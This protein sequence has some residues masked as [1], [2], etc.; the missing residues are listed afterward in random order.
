[1]TGGCSDDGGAC[2]AVCVDVLCSSFF[3]FLFIEAFLGNEFLF[4]FVYEW[5]RANLNMDKIWM[6][7]WIRKYAFGCDNKVWQKLSF[8]NTIKSKHDIL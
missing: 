2:F 3:F 5:I 7:G 6:D 1:M 8:D 4:L